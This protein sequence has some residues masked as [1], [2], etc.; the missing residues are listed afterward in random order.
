VDVDEAAIIQQPETVSANEEVK[1]DDVCSPVL[2]QPT[3]SVYP[4]EEFK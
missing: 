2:I 3:E 1:Q 4:P